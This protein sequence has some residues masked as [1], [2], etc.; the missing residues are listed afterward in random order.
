MTNEEDRDLTD[1][2]MTL[3]H[4]MREQNRTIRR[5]TTMIDMLFVRVAQYAS[6]DELADIA[7]EIAQILKG[8]NDE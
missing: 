8:D 5:M 6:S 2:A 3:I 1:N 4:S 7:D